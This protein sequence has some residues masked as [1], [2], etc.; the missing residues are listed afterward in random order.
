MTQIFRGLIALAVLAGL[1]PIFAGAAS[2]RDDTGDLVVADATAPPTVLDPF[3]VYGTQAQSFF[4]LIFEPLFDR[5][6]DG[7]I[8]TPLLERWGPVDPLTWEFR[9]RPGVRFHDGGE[10]TA[11]DVVYSIERIVD[12]RV[13]SPRRH[14]FREIDTIVAVD[15]LTVRITTK[16]PYALLP[17]RLS[18]FSMI[19]PENLRGRDAADFFREPIGLGP[20]RL[21]ELTSQ[22]GVLNAF[23]DYHGGAPKVSRVVFQ[24]IPEAEERL[25]QLLGGNVDIVTNL[26]PQQ[27][28]SLLRA[29]G[30]RLLKRNSI[31]FTEVFLDTRSGPLGRA[32]ARRALLH[33]TDVE[34]LVR[35]VA[36]GNGR[37]IATVTLPEDFGFHAGLKPRSFDPAKARAL[38]AQAG[39]PDGFHLQGLAT[40][41]TQTLAT[42]LAQQW[43]KIG[44]KLEVTVEGRTQAVNRWIR[45]RD[46]HSFLIADPTSIIFDAAFQLRVHLD[47]AHPM[48]RASHPRA[49]ELLNRADSEQDVTTRASLLREVQALA[50]EEAL[51]LPLYQVVDLYGVRDRVTGFVPSA[52]TILRL[53]GVGLAPVRRHAAGGQ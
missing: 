47:P 31:R 41:D 1:L 30:V 28:D 20:F 3:K 42:A 34:G 32:E 17:A 2:Q 5:A 24:F 49:V 23:A 14:E 13:N 4:R 50:Y 12:A 36:R 44:V 6:P 25:R 53:G 48:A 51:T 18:Q 15:Q 7:T 27:V 52:D 33:G 35:Y 9:L 29:R 11:A 40:H 19:L 21:M 26:L 8:R 46:R 43:A 38:L 16:R 10:L 37:A 39:Y 45:E 22:Q